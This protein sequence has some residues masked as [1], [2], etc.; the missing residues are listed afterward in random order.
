MASF[1]VENPYR[2]LL[3]SPQVFSKA[4]LSRSLVT[5]KC[6]SCAA[7]CSGVQPSSVQSASSGALAERR[8]SVV[9]TWPLRAAKC[10]GEA[11]PGGVRYL[12]KMWLRCFFGFCWVRIWERCCLVRV[13]GFDSILHARKKSVCFLMSV[14]WGCW[15]QP[16]SLCL[17]LPDLE[18]KHLFS[19][20]TGMGTG[21]LKKRSEN[22]LLKIQYLDE[23]PETWS[24]AKVKAKGINRYK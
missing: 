4:T 9:K 11:P 7:A 2:R 15:F 14:Y 23:R 24:P 18:E 13:F 1:S 17:L 20:I 21:R 12:K 19:T 6:P 22:D 16:A 8:S 3:S 5:S 10:K